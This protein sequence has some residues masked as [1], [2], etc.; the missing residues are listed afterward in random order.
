M[1]DNTSTYATLYT[2][3]A[4]LASLLRVIFSLNFFRVVD[5]PLQ[6]VQVFRFAHLLSLNVSHD[7][8]VQFFPVKLQ[9]LLRFYLRPVIPE[10]LGLS[11]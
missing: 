2:D 1:I 6:I 7:T 10:G 9:F 4:T 11:K 3:Y 8:F 5:L